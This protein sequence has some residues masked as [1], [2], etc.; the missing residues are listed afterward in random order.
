MERTVPD[1]L[2]AGKDIP[3]ALFQAFMEDTDPKTYKAL[4]SI[5]KGII[6][7]Q[8]MP[9]MVEILEAKGLV[10]VYQGHIGKE[11]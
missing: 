6:V 11:G 5:G 1:M 2:N 7:I 8:D 3:L 9:R 10:K 4:K